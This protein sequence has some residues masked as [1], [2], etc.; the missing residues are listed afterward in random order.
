MVDVHE[1]QVVP[2]GSTLIFYFDYE[3][4]IFMK[5]YTWVVGADSV[6]EYLRGVIIGLEG[7]EV[8]S[9]DPLGGEA[10]F[11]LPNATSY[12]QGWYYYT[13]SHD[14]SQSV[15]LLRLFAAVLPNT[16]YYEA[17]DTFVLPSFYYRG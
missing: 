9:L 4:D 14:F 12:Q 8:V 11:R 5:F 17:A 10:I 13:E 1:I 6:E 16:T 7:L 15:G 2:H 3:I